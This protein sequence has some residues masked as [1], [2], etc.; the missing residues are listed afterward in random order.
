M[1]LQRVRKRV[2]VNMPH[3][4]SADARDAIGARLGYSCSLECDSEEAAITFRK[5]TD[6]RHAVYLQCQGC[7]GS[8]GGPLKQGQ[9]PDYQSYR[10]WDEDLREQFHN[11]FNL[12]VQE[13][14]MARDAIR[15]EEREQRREDYSLFLR[16]SPDWWALRNRVMKRAN[17]RCEACLDADAKDVHHVTYGLGK[18]PPAYYLRALCR[19]CHARFGAVG[20]EWSGERGNGL[21]F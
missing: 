5:L 10:A 2:C 9:H 11:G 6:G 16:T 3:G 7:G 8:L 17:W 13:A 21:S 20:D 15:Q 4:I 12:R 18:L 1:D 14:R 19:T